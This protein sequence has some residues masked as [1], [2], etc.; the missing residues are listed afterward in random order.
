[1]IDSPILL[2]GIDID[3]SILMFILFIIISAIGSLVNKLREAQEAARRQQRRREAQ[4]RA[5]G[6]E[7]LSLEEEIR[8][9][10][11]GSQAQGRGRAGQAGPPRAPQTRRLTPGQAARA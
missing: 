9:F 10:L 6:K 2:A 5:Q 1:M 3:I 7:E 8:A 11:K 4:M